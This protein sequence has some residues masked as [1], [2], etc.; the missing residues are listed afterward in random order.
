M[1]DFRGEIYDEMAKAA[2]GEKRQAHGQMA[3]ANYNQTA[4]ILEQL[5]RIKS[6]PEADR[7]WLEKLKANVEK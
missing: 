6:L 2:A 1:S 5:D 3:K 7:K 4:D